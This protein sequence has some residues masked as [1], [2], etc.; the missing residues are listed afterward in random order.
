[1]MTIGIAKIN[2]I[3]NKIR[4]ISTIHHHSLYTRCL[5]YSTLEGGCAFVNKS[6]NF[7]CYYS[8]VGLLG[9]NTDLVRR[10]VP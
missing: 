10:A 3:A 6:S 9:T 4:T 1:M 7:F 8:I 2:A 5:D